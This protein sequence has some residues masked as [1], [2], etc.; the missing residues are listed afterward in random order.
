[1]TYIQLHFKFFYAW[2]R[3]VLINSWHFYNYK[4]CNIYRHLNF[5]KHSA[6]YEQLQNRHKNRFYEEFLLDSN[7]PPCCRSIS[8]S[9]FST[10][11]KKKFPVSRK[12]AYLQYDLAEYQV[13]E[14][15]FDCAFNKSTAIIWLKYCQNAVKTLFN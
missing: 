10:K 14:C 1:M 11:K 4:S 12:L 13:N 6:K 7:P 9:K 15:H 5:Q 2:C 8:I 3:I